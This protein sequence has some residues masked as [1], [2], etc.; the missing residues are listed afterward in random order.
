MSS[1]PPLLPPG[2]GVFRPGDEKFDRGDHMGGFNIAIQN[3]LDNIGR[4]PGNYDVK[5]VLSATVRIENPGNVVEYC[6]KL[7]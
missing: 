2:T 7:I 4:A 6:A 5:V 3:A 1:R